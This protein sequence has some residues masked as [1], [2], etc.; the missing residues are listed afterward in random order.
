MWGRGM[1]RR[2]TGQRFVRAHVFVALLLVVGCFGFSCQCWVFC[3][4]RPVCRSQLLFVIR[5]EKSVRGLLGL[6][7]GLFPRGLRSGK[8]ELSP[9]AAGESPLLSDQVLCDAS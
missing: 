9:W 1:V 4:Q 5:V 8:T 3:N 6:E 2:R 7:I